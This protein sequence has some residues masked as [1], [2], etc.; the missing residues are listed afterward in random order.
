MRTSRDGSYGC[1]AQKLCGRI[2]DGSYGFCAPK[3][4]GPIETIAKAL[5]AKAVRTYRTV[6]QAVSHQ[7]C[8][9]VSDDS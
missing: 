4:C 3:L 5:C 2:V 6:A 9:D 1:V 8:A 7:N